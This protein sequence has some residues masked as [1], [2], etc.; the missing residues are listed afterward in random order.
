MSIQDSYHLSCLHQCSAIY[1]VKIRIF[2][3]IDNT[4]NS[5]YR[6]GGL[7]VKL[8]VAKHVQCPVSASPGFDSRPMHSDLLFSLILVVWLWWC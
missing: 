7:V 6:I 3:S 2:T 5:N 1:F 4:F 8:A